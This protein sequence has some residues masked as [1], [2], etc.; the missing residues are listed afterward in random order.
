M[1]AKIY[2]STIEKK[3]GAPC[4][5]GVSESVISGKTDLTEFE[6]IFD[7]KSWM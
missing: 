5:I 1:I 7:L 3:D 6:S 4:Q 2:L